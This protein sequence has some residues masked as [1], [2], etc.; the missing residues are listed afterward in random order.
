M[1]QSSNRFAP[2]RSPFGDLFVEV[3]SEE[4]PLLVPE[5][6]LQEKPVPLRSLPNHRLCEL[7]NPLSSWHS[8]PYPATLVL[9]TPTAFGGLG[10][11]PPMIGS[12]MSFF[13]ILNGIFI[14]FIF[15]RV[16][17]RFDGS[18]RRCAVL[19]F[20]PHYQS[21]SAELCRARWQVG[22]G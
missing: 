1:V 11:D 4:D 12:I 2:R 16:A 7:L 13:G 17:G 9:S 3:G 8:F 20:V 10:Y 14:V 15:S 19:P 5:A 22:A 18:D 6:K 21:F